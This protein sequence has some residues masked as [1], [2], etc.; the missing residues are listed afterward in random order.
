MKVTG[1][2]I[3]QLRQVMRDATTRYYNDNLTFNRL[4]S[5]GG[6]WVNFTL[7][8]VS[9]KG[10]GHRISMM[11]RH[12]TAACWHAHRDFMIELFEQYPKAQLIS[13]Y[14]NYRGKASF[15]AQFEETGYK[16]IGS[17]MQPLM[18]NEACGCC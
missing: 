5:N 6:K 3:T 11:G 16:N 15:R 13:C 12:I 2:D 4:D 7:R 17:I 1:L 18:M 10:P 9:S 8:V 14:A